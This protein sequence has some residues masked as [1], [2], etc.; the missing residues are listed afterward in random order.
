MKRTWI[1][2]YIDQC[3]R[4]SMI[5][6]LTAEQRWLWIGFLLLAGDSSI[7]G[8]IFR[9]KNANGIPLGYS[10]VTLAETLDV[11]I[12]VYDEGIRRMIEKK[13]ISINESGV[14]II[15]NWQKYQSEYERQKKYRKGDKKKCNQ[16]YEVDRDKE[17][18]KEGDKEKVKDESLFE[19]KFDEFWKAY[20]K[21]VAKDYAKKKFMILARKGELANVAKAF[22]GYMDYLK[23]QRLEKNF[24]QEVMN[25]ATFLMENRWKDYIN[26]KYKPRL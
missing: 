7:P 9:R 16:S 13:K 5:E 6:E 14:I 1:K 23:Y 24:E 10:N 3:L 22:S 26:F 18:D 11:D 19:Q 15:L 20:P 4:G 25:P 12:D 8:I 21:K 2:L 17:G